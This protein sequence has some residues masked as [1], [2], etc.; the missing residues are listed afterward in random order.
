MMR[1]RSIVGLLAV[2]LV[3]AGCSLPGRVSGSFEVVAEFDD[4]NDLVVNHGVQVADVRVGSVTSIELTDDLRHARITMHVKEGLGL[5]TDVVA[6]LRQTS[7][8]GEKFIELRPRE[9]DDA[10]DCADQAAP[11]T[12]DADLVATCSIQA[13]ELEAVTEDAVQLLGAVMTNDLRT[14]VDTGALGFG[15]R[16]AELRSIIDDL[17]TVSATLASQT[18]NILTILDGLDQA[19]GTLAAGASDLDALL[20]N[21]SNTVALLADNRQ[22]AVDTLAALTELARTQNDLIFEPHLEA[23][24]RQ[25]QELDAILSEL[26]NGKAEVGALLD[27]LINFIHVIPTALPCEPVGQLATDEAPACNEG[28]FAQIYGWIIAAPLEPAP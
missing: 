9:D 28:D 20:V 24:T 18:T 25:I 23:T 13:P 1:L 21:L 15:G 27:W 2:G 11:E 10:G 6:V 14:L 19:A 22:Q 3:A 4:V 12:G 7:L 8:L 5:P 26:H 17:S 16:G